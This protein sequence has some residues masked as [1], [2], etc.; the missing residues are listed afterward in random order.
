MTL[1]GPKRF[2]LNNQGKTSTNSALAP[3]GIIFGV[4]L[5][6]YGRLLGAQEHNA[7]GQNDRQTT[8]ALGLL[9]EPFFL[10]YFYNYHGTFPFSIYFL[11]L[12]VIV[13]VI[14]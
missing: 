14:H 9:S 11:N 10:F 5:G 13:I 7:D 12:R 4:L 2:L 1:G 3:K 8:Y 6:F